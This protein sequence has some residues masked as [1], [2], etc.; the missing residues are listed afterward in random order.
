MDAKQREMII[1]DLP[2]H[3]KTSPLMGKVSIRTPHYRPVKKMYYLFNL[4]EGI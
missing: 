2:G 3:G 4:L 1:S